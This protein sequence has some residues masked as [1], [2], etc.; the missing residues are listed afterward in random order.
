M[1]IQKQN[2]HLI[3]PPHSTRRA[4]SLVHPC[5]KL[6]LKEDY[7]ARPVLHFKVQVVSEYALKPR[8]MRLS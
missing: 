5:A 2:G 3:D 7:L 4:L 1:A 8:S 6:L